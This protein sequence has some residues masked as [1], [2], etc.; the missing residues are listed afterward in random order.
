[1]NAPRILLDPAAVCRR[2]GGVALALVAINMGLQ[3]ARLVLQQENLPGLPMLSL[4][5]ENN[6]P[7][8]FSTLLLFTAALI[9]AF[10]ALLERVRARQDAPK[11]F[12][13]A[14]GFLLM[15][16]DESLSLH[17][18]MIEPMLR[19]LGGR[20]NTT[21]RPVSRNRTRERSS[22]GMRRTAITSDVS[23]RSL[24]FA[25]SGGASS[26]N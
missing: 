22:G 18:R 25:I 3:V 6:V 19:G 15:G 23:A 13:L 5:K 20:S 4:D 17:E 2:L 24:S 1:M 21:A 11:W 12:I 8:L 16:V 14:A 26:I 7:A 10:V 9:L